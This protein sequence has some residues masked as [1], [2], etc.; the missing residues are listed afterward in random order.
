M[1]AA[2][3]IEPDYPQPVTTA[4]PEQWAL[5]YT[6]PREEFRAT[7][8]L[9][10]AKFRVYLP[11]R[12]LWKRP[13]MMG[14]R[15]GKMLLCEVPRYD[16]YLFVGVDDDMRWRKILASRG[17]ASLITN[18]AG[19]PALLP[20]RLIEIVRA[21]VAAEPKPEL[22]G[23]RADWKPGDLLMVLS[24]IYSQHRVTFDAWEGE[25]CR[26]FITI[27]GRTAKAKIDPKYLSP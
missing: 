17:V 2:A 10:A 6:H 8:S 1:M 15:S 13:R 24:G 16:R 21:Q 14:G 5:A 26:V 27:F 3:V 18:S 7:E 25:Q 9:E 4:E 22:R 12:W 11:T 23:K 19:V 20:R